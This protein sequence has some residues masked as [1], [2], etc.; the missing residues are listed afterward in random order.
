MDTYQV[1]EVG[2]REGAVWLSCTQPQEA[3]AILAE[4]RTRF[5]EWRARP[6]KAYTSSAGDEAG[7][8][9]DKCG[10]RHRYALWW[11]ISQLCS[12]GWEP[13][14][15]AQDISREA[16]SGPLYVFRKRIQP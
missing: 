5:P 8:L 13:L 9:V 6:R 7:W 10:G 4:L 12:R 2:E 15:V 16:Y 11:L 14:A 3:Q 1:A